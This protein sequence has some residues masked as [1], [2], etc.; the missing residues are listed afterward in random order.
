[1]QSQKHPSNRFLRLVEKGERPASVSMD[2]VRE[3]ER[4]S[5]ILLA[6]AD[7]IQASYGKNPY[8]DFVR[9]HGKRP[10]R[11]QAACIGRLLGGRVRADDGSMQPPLTKADRAALRAIKAHQAAWSHQSNH[12]YRI[13]NAVAELCTNVDDPAI[14]AGYAKAWLKKESNRERLAVALS[15]L[16]RFAEES[17]IYDKKES[18]AS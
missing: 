14:V 5:R 10:S 6:N 2:V 7:A 4:D 15:W 17:G 9:K 12:L 16:I 11:E 3:G 18:T 1:V 8:T 13:E